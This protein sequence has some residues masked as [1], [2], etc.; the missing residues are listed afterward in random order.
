M[1]GAKGR[2]QPYQNRVENMLPTP[3]FDEIYRQEMEKL[4]VEVTA[5]DARDGLG[6]TDCG[7]ISQVVPTIQPS[8]CICKDKVPGHSEAFKAAA[9]SQEG[10]D[11]VP[12][13]A[14]AL[15]LTALRLLLEPD[16]LHSI[17]EEHAR[18]VSEQ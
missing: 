1:T 10:L 13:G 5:S 16:T 3:S 12:R 6:S 9:C 15:A 17:Q 11:S 8:I 18:I 4:G 14:S 7:N 2:M